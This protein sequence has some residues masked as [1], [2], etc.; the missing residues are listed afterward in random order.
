MTMS[1]D[2]REG[3]IWVNGKMVEWQDATT[4]IINHGLHYGGSVFEGIRAYNGKPFKL[5]QHNQRLIDSGKTIGMDV[6]YSVETLN[7]ACLDIM[8]KNDLTNCYFRPIAW[9][10]SEEMGIGASSCSTNVAIAAWEWG[11]YFD[12]TDGITLRTSQWKKPAPDTA[13]TSSKCAAG[14]VIGTMAKHES[15]SNGYHDALM[16]DYRGYVAESSGANLFM[17]KNGEIFTPIPDCFLNGITRQTI[18]GLARDNGLSVTEKH[19]SVDELM[20]A[21][22]IFVTGTAAEVT[23]VGK[24]DDTGFKVG[25]VTKQ[26]IELYKKETG[27][28]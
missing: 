22:E 18:I 23:A 11:Q 4:H 6:P 21:D 1:F 7:Q 3:W 2:Q 10:G 12:G 9:R 28:V 16:L 5:T 24:I 8:K 20:S 15:V 19:I 14:Y 17:I 13:A 25:D 26:L 27:Q